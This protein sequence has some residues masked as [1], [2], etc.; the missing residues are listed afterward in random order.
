MGQREL[1]VINVHVVFWAYPVNT[2]CISYINSAGSILPM[3][4]EMNLIITMWLM[5]DKTK[6]EV[7]NQ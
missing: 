6:T 4:L 2:N 1:K 3:K 7:Q 5:W